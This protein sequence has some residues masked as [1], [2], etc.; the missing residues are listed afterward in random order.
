[1]AQVSSS[2][3]YLG[4]G[5]DHRV[6]DHGELIKA[7]IGE[8]PLC[9]VRSVD[10]G[11]RSF[12]REMAGVWPGQQSVAISATCG[13]S[14]GDY[15]ADPRYLWTAVCERLFGTHPAQICFEWNTAAHVV[16][17]EGRPGRRALTKR[18]LQRFFDY[19]DE[20]V[21]EAWL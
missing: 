14:W 6:V 7:P 13:S 9:G 11:S 2:K 10:N 12:V 1:M 21:T 5:R 3:L 20:R 16:E 18:E 4:E 15:V 19:S 17:Y 8:C